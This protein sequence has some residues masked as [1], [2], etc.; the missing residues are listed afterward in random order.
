[1]RPA[2]TGPDVEVFLPGEG[3]LTPTGAT[4]QRMRKDVWTA[5]TRWDEGFLRFWDPLTQRAVRLPAKPQAGEG[6]EQAALRAAWLANPAR[7]IP[8][9]HISIE[10]VLGWAQGF[11]EALPANASRTALVHSLNGD[12]P[13]HN[14]TQLV[15]QVG[16]GGRWHLHH[17][18]AV[19]EVVEEWQGR[20]NVEIDL[21]PE[22]EPPP[23]ETFDSAESTGRKT[24][25]QLSEADIRGHIHRLVDRMTLPELLMLVV[26]YRLTL[27]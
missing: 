24:T 16:L 3:L 5:F 7:F 8:I 1:I 10:T 2:P 18:Q 25:T 12:L 17:L 4:L 19:R 15:R 22:A 27:D 14:F 6:P 21:R 26:P 13:L 11:V 20:Y 9:D 23:V